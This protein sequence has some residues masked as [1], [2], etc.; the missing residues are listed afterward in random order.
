MASNAIIIPFRQTAH[1]PLCLASLEV[2]GDIE[3]HQIILA[4][5][6]GTPYDFNRHDLQLSHWHVYDQDVFHYSKLLNGAVKRVRTEWVTIL[7]PDVLVPFDF[8]AQME[9]A[10]SEPYCGRFYFPIRYLDSTATQCVELRFNSLYERIIPE[11]ERWRRGSEAYKRGV[12]GTE[13]FSIRTSSYLELGG[14]DERFH[15]RTLAH[16]DFGRRWLNVCVPPI[17]VECHLF[18]RW[19]RTGFFEGSPGDQ[20]NERTLFAEK[21]RQEFPPLAMTREWGMF[22]RKET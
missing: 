4:Q 10:Q 1:I 19:R 8:I 2:C 18:H 22:E 6:G 5:H 13:C 7:Q 3:Q 17:C 21:E 15:E 14:Y 9:L 12:I 20:A 16:I 11:Q